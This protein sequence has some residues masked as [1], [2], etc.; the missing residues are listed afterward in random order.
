MNNII[1]LSGSRGFIGTY[2]KDALIG[3]NTAVQCVSNSNTEDNEIIF[4]DFSKKKSI[5]EALKKYGTPDTFIHL[6]WGDVYEPHNECHVNENLMDGQNLID[7]LYA[8]GV[9]RI[10]LIGS[11]SELALEFIKILSINEEFKIHTISW[12]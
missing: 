11:S 8:A 4:I 2:L 5:N 3:M 6:G 7:E 1:W 9:K 10:L 12:G